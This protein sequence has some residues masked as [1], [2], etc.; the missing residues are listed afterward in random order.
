MSGYI[1]QNVLVLE[2]AEHE[3]V[4]V[5]E[6]DGETISI[7]ENGFL[8]IKEVRNLFHPAG[9]CFVYENKNPGVKTGV[10]IGGDERLPQIYPNCSGT[11]DCG[12][13]PYNA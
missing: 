2:A 12:T 1:G 11:S 8:S 10:Y 5:Y 3:Y 6:V 4:H 13:E 9:W 7:D